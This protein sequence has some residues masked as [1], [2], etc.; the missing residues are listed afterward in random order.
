M[1][2][3]SAIASRFA[4]CS[5]ENVGAHTQWG[6]VYGATRPTWFNHHDPL[7]LSWLATSLGAFHFPYGRMCAD[8]F[9]N[10]FAVSGREA[11]AR[12]VFHDRVRE[13]A[14]WRVDAN[15]AIAQAMVQTIAPVIPKKRP[16]AVP[17]PDISPQTGGTP[18]G[19][20]GTWSTHASQAFAVASMYPP[21]KASGISRLK[22]INKSLLIECNSSKAGARTV[23]SRGHNVPKCGSDVGGGACRSGQ[24]HMPATA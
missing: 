10:Q 15:Q 9:T 4:R 3:P 14:A 2:L 21:E 11:G 16:V 19:P 17:V 12:K 7:T 24:S 13:E 18:C 23:T 20:L 5:S 1:Y 8:R 6:T 22:T